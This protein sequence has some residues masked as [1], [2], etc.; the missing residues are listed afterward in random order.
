MQAF[1]RVFERIGP[2]A[3]AGLLCAIPF[4]FP[5]IEINETSMV[6]GSL[7]QNT[8]LSPALRMGSD[9]VLVVGTRVD[10]P[11]PSPDNIQTLMHH[12]PGSCSAKALNALLLDPVHQDLNRIDLINEILSAGQRLY[13]DDFIEKINQ[14]IGL[15]LSRKLSHHQYPRH[16]SI[17]RLGKI[18]GDIW[19]PQTVEATRGTRF[20]LSTVAG[21]SEE[22][23]L[24]SYLLFD[25]SYTAVI[26]DLGYQDAMAKET[27][28]TALKDASRHLIR[29]VHHMQL[30][31]IG[32]RFRECGKRQVGL[33]TSG[34]DSW[35]SAATNPVINTNS[36][37]S[38]DLGHENL[39]RLLRIGDRVDHPL[40]IR[41]RAGW[42]RNGN[43][44]FFAMTDFVPTAL[45]AAM[46]HWSSPRS[47]EKNRMDFPDQ[48]GGE[49]DR[50]SHRPTVESSYLPRQTYLRPPGSCESTQFVG[51]AA[52]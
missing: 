16:P 47:L 19:D 34:H 1:G 12:P 25:A 45:D 51:P 11:I 49:T 41:L 13:G 18:A 32:T 39:V 33:A 15:R 29:D 24:L 38:I 44:M 10:K 27:A 35:F 17:G 52:S 28:I 30:A 3:R 40:A 8:P 9:N 14:D 26:E 6:D 4:L 42:A 36:T 5:P 31:P 22:A 48:T 50:H 23:D 2:R 37:A 43:R 7:R 46:S 20:M 21:D